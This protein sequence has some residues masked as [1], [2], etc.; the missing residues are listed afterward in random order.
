M[1]M[2]CRIG[3]LPVG[4]GIAAWLN[5]HVGQSLAIKCRYVSVLRRDADKAVRD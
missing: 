3:G 1:Q 5:G 2:M 4:S